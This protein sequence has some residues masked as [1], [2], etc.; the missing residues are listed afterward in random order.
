MSCSMSPARRKSIQNTRPC[1]VLHTLKVQ[2]IPT[3]QVIQQINSPRQFLEIW[4]VSTAPGLL[5]WACKLSGVEY[6]LILLN[7]ITPFS[8]SS[9]CVCFPCP[10]FSLALYVLHHTFFICFTLV[11]LTLSAA[12]LP[13]TSYSS[14]FPVCVRTL[15]NICV[16]FLTQAHPPSHIPFIHSQNCCSVI[17]LRLRPF[18][19]VL[20]DRCGEDSPSL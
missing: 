8:D 12:S 7:F 20:S 13:T 1:G 16:Y 4:P 3:E 18:K 11:S 17:C 14:C 19:W 6:T 10:F 2:S 15:M 5:C 9:H